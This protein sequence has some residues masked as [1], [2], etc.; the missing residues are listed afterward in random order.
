MASRSPKC[1]V[2]LGMHRSGTSALARVLSLA[3]AELPK[4]VMSANQ[5]N[6]RGYW[7]PERLVALND[8]ILADA[9]ISWHNWSAA[10]PAVGPEK[11]AYYRK[12]IVRIITEEYDSAPLLLIKDPRICRLVQLWRAALAE[13]RMEAVFA[14]SLRNPLEVAR[15]LEERDGLPLIHGCLLW[16]RYVLDMETGTRDAR[17]VFVPYHELLRDPAQTAAGVASHLN[18]ACWT[19]NE[20][21]RSEIRS[22]IDPELRHHVAELEDLRQLVP[23][24][25]PLA[26]TYE[27]VSTLV[28]QPTDATACRQLDRTRAAF[29][30]ATES[31][32]QLLSQQ[33]DPRGS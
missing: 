22:F 25:S 11:A 5:S 30:L 32:A 18:G 23:L 31:F 28:R 1:I 6:E 29:D 33:Q 3:G 10:N 2:V 21:V 24:Y 8:E 17:R 20:D 4:H 9:G 13:G 16:L 7:E 14:V 19:P 15:S 27:A 12:A 26:E